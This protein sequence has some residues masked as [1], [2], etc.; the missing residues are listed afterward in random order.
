MKSLEKSHRFYFDFFFSSQFFLFRIRSMKKIHFLI[1]EFYD[2]SRST[3]RRVSNWI[4]PLKGSRKR[5]KEYLIIILLTS[6]NRYFE[7][8]LLLNVEHNNLILMNILGAHK[9]VS[10][11][12]GRNKFMI[13]IHRSNDVSWMIY[14]YSF[15]IYPDSFFKEKA[16]YRKVICKL[17]FYIEIIKKIRS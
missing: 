17:F 5:I 1:N 8:D 9:W 2:R 15:C 3:W 16:R 11:F 14:V 13:I 10:D 12:F 7:K 6:Y 4:R